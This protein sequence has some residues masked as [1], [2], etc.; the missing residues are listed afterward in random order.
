MVASGPPH[1][2]SKV[3]NIPRRDDLCAKCL[4]VKIHACAYGYTDVEC[5]DVA[6]GNTRTCV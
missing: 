1:P 4:I 3:K 6:M 5:G 2:I